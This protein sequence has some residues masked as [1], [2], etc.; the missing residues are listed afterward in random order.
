MAVA[1]GLLVGSSP[2][3]SWLAAIVPQGLYVKSGTP[4]VAAQ[5]AS[6]WLQQHLP[7]GPWMTHH[8]ADRVTSLLRCVQVL[9][10]CL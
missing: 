7:V 3:L 5:A 1:G 9:Y 2:V 6:L 4:E 10:R 8:R